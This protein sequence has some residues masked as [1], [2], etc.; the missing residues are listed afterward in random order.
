MRD[1]YKLLKRIKGILQ[2]YKP[3]RLMV[4]SLN[5]LKPLLFCLLIAPVV[6]TLSISLTT[7]L[8]KQTIPKIEWI[9]CLWA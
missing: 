4:C 8:V 6:Y 7:K 2:K 5:L 1:S 9:L 3:C